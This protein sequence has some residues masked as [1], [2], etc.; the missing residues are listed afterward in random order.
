MEKTKLSIERCHNKLK[1]I[2]ERLKDI[3]SSLDKIEMSRSKYKHR[4]TFTL[5]DPSGDGH[6]FYTKYYLVCNYSAKEIESAYKE[7]CKELGFNFLEL[8]STYKCSKTIEKRYTKILLNAG[9]ID[10]TRVIT[11][12]TILESPYY[13]KEDLGTYKLRG[14]REYLEIFF[15]IVHKKLQ[16]L[17]WTLVKNDFETLSVL[18]GTGYGLF[19]N[20]YN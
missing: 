6:G 13:T 1:E 15:S 3:N 8:F 9:C 12:E 4:L 20:L 7:M 19:F 2:K 11:N 10:P 17:V 16:D 5:G 14:E 18:D